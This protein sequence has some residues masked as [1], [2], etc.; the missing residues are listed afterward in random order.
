M[1]SISLKDGVPTHETLSNLLLW[2]SVL[3][4]VMSIARRTWRA[5]HL[6]LFAGGLFLL[7]KGDRFRYDLALLSLPLLSAN[8]LFDREGWR[9]LLPA[10]ARAMLLACL[11]AVPP[12]YLCSGFRNRPRYPFTTVRLPS[13]VAAFLRAAD[14]GGSV[15][16]NGDTGGYL[17]WTLF[18]RYKIAW[19]LQVG[20]LL[21]GDRDLFMMT[22]AFLDGKV[23]GPMISEYHP[24]YIS[25]PLNQRE[26]PDL[27]RAH[28]QYVPV[29]F[30]DV[31]VLY[32]DRTRQ[33]KLVARSRL[34]L[35]PYAA[36]RPFTMDLRSCAAPKDPLARALDEMIAV[37]PDAVTTRV[38]AGRCALERK[39]P[40]AAL[41][42]AE[43]GIRSHPESFSGYTLRALA[44]REQGAWE[45]ALSDLR[46]AMGKADPK[47]RRWLASQLSETLKSAGR[48]DE[49]VQALREGGFDVPPD[50]WLLDPE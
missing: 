50:E 38:L 8:P 40:A 34:P 26:F 20:P 11:L 10:P 32:A 15:L 35:D 31:E 7:S 43:A 30:D 17:E 36:A 29:F 37:D 49:A 21:F 22:H 48:N 25:A 42:H 44:R 39:E 1:V 2:T 46:V 24:D 5:S 28:P 23:L 14:T 3:C 12:L 4:A 27:I 33:P 45:P 41:A 19:D 18:P 9:G 6:L 16:N 47:V 13:G